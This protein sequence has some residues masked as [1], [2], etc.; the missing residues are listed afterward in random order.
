MIFLNV[1]WFFRSIIV[2]IPPPPAPS[3]K[4]SLDPWATTSVPHNPSASDDF[5][6]FAS[7]QKAETKTANSGWT[8]FE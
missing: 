5:G 4:I 1:D 8:K 6:D 2:F 3:S 7:V